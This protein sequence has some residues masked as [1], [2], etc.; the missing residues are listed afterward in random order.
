M[1]EAPGR[2]RESD[3]DATFLVA[4]CRF[5]LLARHWHLS[6]HGPEGIVASCDT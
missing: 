2:G 1:G 5:G 4:P 6:G 3:A